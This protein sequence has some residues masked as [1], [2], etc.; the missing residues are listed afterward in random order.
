MVCIGRKAQHLGSQG[1]GH[2]EQE[3]IL[4]CAGRSS[5]VL[6]RVA[7]TSPSPGRRRVWTSSSQLRSFTWC[8]LFSTLQWLRNPRSSSF[9]PHLPGTQAGQQ[10]PALPAH[11][12]GGY[13]HFHLLHHCPLP[14]P[15]VSQLLPDIISQFG[16]GPNPP[17]FNHPRF[18]ST[19]S[20]AGSPSSAPANP[21]T[22]A[23]STVGWFPLTRTR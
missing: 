2:P 9:G 21:S 3:T 14:R 16:I 12:S 23:D 4:P 19:V 20:P 1:H 10:M 8:R 18:F 22:R 13:V 15:R 7:Y 17:P 6:T 5:A 11:L